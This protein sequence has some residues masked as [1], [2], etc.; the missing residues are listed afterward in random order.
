MEPKK[1]GSKVIG[2]VGGKVTGGEWTQVKPLAMVSFNGTKECFQA[3]P[4]LGLAPLKP[5]FPW[6]RRGH[7]FTVLCAAAKRQTPRTPSVCLAF[8]ISTRVCLSSP[9]T[10]PPVLPHNHPSTLG[11]IPK[12]AGQHRLCTLTTGALRPPPGEVL[13]HV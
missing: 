11:W 10:W 5:N 12:G 4:W 2:Q 1:K 8:T 9:S 3:E 6:E 7:L 13:S